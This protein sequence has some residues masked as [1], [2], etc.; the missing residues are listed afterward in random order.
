MKSGPGFHVCWTVYWPCDYISALFVTTPDHNTYH[1]VH[2]ACPWAHGL[3][4]GSIRL[5]HD[6]TSSSQRE[7]TASL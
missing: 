7:T 6:T 1:I 4:T 5:Q 3:V 2:V